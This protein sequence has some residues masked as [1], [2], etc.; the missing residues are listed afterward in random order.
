MC[1]TKYF[2]RFLAIYPTNLTAILDKKEEYTISFFYL[3]LL[4]NGVTF[5]IASLAPGKR[6]VPT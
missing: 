6:F 5:T 1:F 3:K 4:K 2:I